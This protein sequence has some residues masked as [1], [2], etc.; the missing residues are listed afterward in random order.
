M[1][2]LD[3]GREIEV[4]MRCE[5]FNGVAGGLSFD[6]ESFMKISNSKTLLAGISVTWAVIRAASAAEVEPEFVQSPPMAFSVPE[7]MPSG[8][9]EISPLWLNGS[10]VVGANQYRL[11]VL[12]ETG[13]VDLVVTQSSGAK[14]SIKRFK[15]ANA[16]GVPSGAATSLTLPAAAQSL[17]MRLGQNAALQFV[18]L[19]NESVSGTCMVWL[20]AS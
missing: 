10:G 20:Q 19:Y 2:A 17:M 3:S 15:G 12:A 18:Y 8:G 6:E 4:G 5:V 14:C 1:F 9:K 16:D 11:V 7:T 13:I